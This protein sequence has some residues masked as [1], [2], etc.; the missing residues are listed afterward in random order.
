MDWWGDGLVG[1]RGTSSLLK[2]GYFDLRSKWRGQIAQANIVMYLQCKQ[3]S[4][5]KNLRLK[6]VIPEIGRNRRLAGGQ[7][8]NH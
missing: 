6:T 2:G 5:R 1:K 8:Y 4:E 7:G 3:K